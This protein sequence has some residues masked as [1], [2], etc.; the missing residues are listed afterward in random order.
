M[1]RCQ[2][3][4]T[5]ETQWYEEGCL[6]L[7]IGN[8]LE[9]LA[10]SL[11]RFDRFLKS[12]GASPRLTYIALLALEE[13]VSNTIKYGY[14]DPGQ[15]HICLV[16]TIG[17]PAVMTIQDNGHPFNPL[18]DAPLPDLN[19]MAEERPIGGLGLHLVRTLATSVSYRRVDGGNRLDIVFSADLPEG[20]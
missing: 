6:R 5:L 18:V 15:H 13:L 8:H 10:E 11:D 20:R 3:S 4:G 1:I 12:A 9:G 17:P 7:T 2:V 19:A 14:D 16:F